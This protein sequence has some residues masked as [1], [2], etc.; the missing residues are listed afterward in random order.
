[1]PGRKSGRSALTSLLTGHC[2]TKVKNKEGIFATHT[3]NRTFTRRSIVATYG[4]LYLEG[5]AGERL[6]HAFALQIP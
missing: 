4:V 2:K 5:G 1:M 6:K 3:I